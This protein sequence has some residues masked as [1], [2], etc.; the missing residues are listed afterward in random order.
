M[1]VCGPATCEEADVA[2]VLG[3]SQAS[4]DAFTI[5]HDAPRRR[6]VHQGSCRRRRRQA[7]H[8]PALVGGRGLVTFPHTLVVATSSRSRS[9]T[10]SARPTSV[11]GPPRR[12]GRRAPRRRQRPALVPVRAGARTED[13]AGRRSGRTSGR[14][15][16]TRRRS[17][18]GATTHA[19]RV[20]A[21]GRQRRETTLRPSTSATTPR[22][23][24]SARCRTTTPP[25]PAATCCSRPAVEDQ[26]HSVYSGLIRLRPG[27]Q[28]VVANQTNRNLVLTEGAGP[29]R[30]RTSRSRP[31]T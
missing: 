1:V 10:A 29:T 3:R 18:W 24:T 14:D 11:I 20:A 12:R 21:R 30:S 25:T 15:R 28:G 23:S 8:R 16:C 7:D 6:G 2:E 5:L 31:T 13:V 26:A 9:S 22:C 4:P 19:V 17:R 27:A